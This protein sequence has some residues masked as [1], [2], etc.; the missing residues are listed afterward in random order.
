MPLPTAP[1]TAAFM[2]MLYEFLPLILFLI[3]LFPI[4]IAIISTAA[5]T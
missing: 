1:G 5:A 3:A 4:G 2:A